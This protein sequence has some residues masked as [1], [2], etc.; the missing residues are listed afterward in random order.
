LREVDCFEMSKSCTIVR[1]LFGVVAG[2]VEEDI[3]KRERFVF[4]REYGQMLWS[5]KFYNFFDGQVKEFSAYD[6]LY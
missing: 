1:L 5:G 6:R 2:K 3:Y 4:D